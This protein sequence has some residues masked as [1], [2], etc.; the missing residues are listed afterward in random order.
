MKKTKKIYINIKYNARLFSYGV[1]T[2]NKLS[3]NTTSFDSF[4]F[5]L[6][7]TRWL[8]LNSPKNDQDKSLPEVLKTVG[9]G[10]E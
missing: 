4:V 10:R 9:K 7:S 5:S 2:E 3:D 1:S 8:T 6:D